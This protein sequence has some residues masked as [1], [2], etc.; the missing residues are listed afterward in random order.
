MAEIPKI[1]QGD[2]GYL[3]VPLTISKQAVTAEDLPLFHCIEF[4][5]GETI[6]KMWPEQVLFH[7]GKFH[8]PYTQEETFA[9]ETGT[10]EVDVRI[11][12]VSDP[13]Q[14]VGLKEDFP[15]VKVVKAT[16]E[17]VL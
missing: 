15:K 9:L 14:V 17:V 16:S 7:D 12:F 13:A 11:H 2:A 8:V 10:I 5:I 1:K 4:Y 6:R 3:G